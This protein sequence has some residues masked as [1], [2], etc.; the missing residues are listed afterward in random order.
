VF[1]LVWSAVVGTRKNEKLFLN[2]GGFFNLLNILEIAPMVIKRQIIGCV[3]DFIDS[4]DQYAGQLFVQWSSKI[5]SRSALRIVM[6]IW[7]HDQK[8]SDSLKEDGT[9]RNL[10]YPL[11]PKKERAGLR[12]MRERQYSTGLLSRSPLMSSNTMGR[13][14]STV[15]FKS[16]DH[17]R[18]ILN[19]STQ[20]NSYTMTG[21][22][23]SSEEKRLAEAVREDCRARIYAIVS[24]IGYEG[25]E[26]LTTEE[27]QAIELIRMLPDCM[28]LEKWMEVQN[29]LIATELKPVTSDR[30]WIQQSIEE[31][32][33]KTAW[34][35][36]VQTQLMD[37]K[38]TEDY[39]RLVHFYDDI[40]AR[41]D[42]MDLS[43][44]KKVI[45]QTT[46]TKKSWK[47]AVSQGSLGSPKGGD[48]PPMAVTW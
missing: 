23:E 39:E 22:V 17:P 21:A 15:G 4:P 13:V 8:A 12:D 3:A 1:D 45:E 20:I 44:T 27:M 5:S 43:L 9:I 33:T 48:A 30:N 36:S 6:E 24:K 26:A 11:N 28:V 14:G 19:Q 47:S 2:G 41:A 35:E 29:N 18:D 25:H 42:N 38:Y 10:E 16:G 32:K 46:S 37:Q 7:H 31:Q 40:R 34:I